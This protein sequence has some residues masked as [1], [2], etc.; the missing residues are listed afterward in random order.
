MI[1]ARDPDE[2]QASIQQWAEGFA[3]KA[4]RY[5]EAAARTEDLRL[6]AT[7][8]GG[9][10]TVTVRADG[11]VAD[12]E[13]GEKASSVPLSELSAMILDTMH[14]AQSRIADQVSEVYAD[15]L[16]DEDPQTRSLMLT[17]LRERFPAADEESEVDDG[18]EPDDYS[19]D[20]PLR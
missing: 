5:Q 9:L 10:V 7:S 18:A 19:D 12:I 8:Q 13:F 2:A 3:A 6:T 16:G 1:P 17:N 4:A 15:E 11:G 20:D 14:R